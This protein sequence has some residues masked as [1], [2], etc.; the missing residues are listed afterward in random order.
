MAKL[1]RPK[2]GDDFEIV[3]INEQPVKGPTSD[4]GVDMSPLVPPPPDSVRAKDEEARGGETPRERVQK[5][6]V[7][8]PAPEIERPEPPFEIPNDFPELAGPILPMPPEPGQPAP[9]EA[10]SPGDRIDFEQPGQP[11]P[12]RPKEPTPQAGGVTPG[13]PSGVIPFQPLPSPNAVSSNVALRR[14]G[15]GLLGSLGG[16]K[17]GGLGLPFD[18][19]SNQQSPSIDALLNLLKR[20]R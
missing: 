1:R 16:L 14:P 8:I 4:A 18:P 3:P 6:P 10:P 11:V 15:G 2:A 5:R 17:G 20:G 9:G 7:P 19:M 13:G 12:E